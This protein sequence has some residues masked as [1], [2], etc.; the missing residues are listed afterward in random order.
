MLT[1]SAAVAAFSSRSVE[2]EGI[3]ASPIDLLICDGVNMQV[4]KSVPYNTG[5]DDDRR[6]ILLTSA[7][8]GAAFTFAAE[9]SG[10]FE[11]DFRVYSDVTPEV[12][13]LQ[14]Y[15]A[16]RFDLE[17]LTFTFTDVEN[18]NSFSV[19]VY[20]GYTAYNILPNAKVK[21][22]YSTI[23]YWY[24]K[25]AL[26]QT[27]L[28]NKNYAGY[29]TVFFGTSF[30]NTSY[31]AGGFVNGN[32]HSNHI[33]FDPASMEV[34]GYNYNENTGDKE[35]RV[36][37]DL[38]D[39]SVIGKYNCIEGFERYTVS[40][41]MSKITSG[42][43]GKV[44]LYALGG[45]SLSGRTFT[46]DA[47]PMFY[48][49]KDQTDGVVG[50]KIA[51]DIPAVCFDTICGETEF[52]G[53]IAV[54]TP[55]GELL[56]IQS[57]YFTPQEGGDYEVTY[58]AVDAN[59]VTGEIT[60][61]FY[62]YEKVPETEITYSFKAFNEDGEAFLPLNN[63]MVLPS[64]AIY[65]AMAREIYAVKPSVKDAEGEACSLDGDFFVPS[66][67]GVYTVLYEYT[68]PA[69]NTVADK[70]TVIAADV[71]GTELTFETEKI[72]ERDTLLMLPVCVSEN[73]ETGVAEVVYPSG[74]VSGGEM[75]YLDEVGGYVLK[76]SFAENENEY[77]ICRYF[78]V[79][80]TGAS[81]FKAVNNAEIVND[82]TAPEYFGYEYNG[83]G[84]NIKK[85]GATIMYDG[86]LDLSRSTKRDVLLD[87][88]VTPQTA[89][90]EEFKYFWITLTDIHD[91]D[92]YISICIR[93]DPWGS[94]QQ[95]RCSVKTSSMVDYWGQYTQGN[96]NPM[97]N[98]GT[99]VAT[100][101]FGKFSE[102]FMAHS[103]KL[104]Y[105]AEENAVYVS[106]TAHA[107]EL[108]D[109]RYLV[110]DLDDEDVLGSAYTF[111]GFTT[112]EV[113]LTIEAEGVSSANASYIIKTVA[114][115]DL[116]GAMLSGDSFPSMIVDIENTAP[117]GLTGSKYKI[118][119]ASAYD[120][121]DGT[122]EVSSE[123]Y[124]KEGGGLVR[125]YNPLNT[126]DY[127]VPDQAGIYYIVYQ[128]KNS[129]GRIITKE[130]GITVK[131]KLSDFSIDFGTPLPDEML[132]GEKLNIGDYSILG[133]SGKTECT[134]KIVYN[135]KEE[136]AG[137]IFQPTESGKYTLRFYLSDYVR[138]ETLEMDISVTDGGL[139]IF[140]E[141]SVPEYALAG[142][143]IVF[144]LPEAK[145]YEK[146]EIYDAAVK[147]TVTE[148]GKET[149]LAANAYDVTGTD[150]EI[151]NVKYE[152]SANGKIFE[153]VYTVNIVSPE[154]LKDYWIAENAEA[155]ELADSLLFRAT[156]EKTVLKF[157]NA[158]LYS[159]YSLS[160]Q[161][162]EGYNDF[163]AVG[164]VLSDSEKTAE[165]VEIEFRKG[166]NTSAV[167]VNGKYKGETAATFFGSIQNFYISLDA[168]Y[169]L[170]DFG[171][172]LICKL[173]SYINNT[174]FTG[175]SSGK[176][177][178]QIAFSGNKGTSGIR[179]FTLGN[180]TFYDSYYDEIKPV[181]TFDSEF[182]YVK[183]IGDEVVLSGAYA[184]D[185]LDPETELN[186]TVRLDGETV[187][188]GAY[189]D[190]LRFTIDKEGEYIITFTCADS[191]GNNAR[192]TRTFIAVAEGG[193]NINVN[194]SVPESGKTGKTIKLPSASVDS[195][196]DY[197]LFIFVID[198]LGRFMAAEKS[199]TPEINGV[200][201][202]RYAVQS[203]GGNIYFQ[204]YHITVK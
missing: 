159:N 158:T 20:G 185:V 19:V 190:D 15:N 83:V 27:K 90:V 142:K 127:F 169:N 96:F 134:V 74:K 131:D 192:T 147:I 113:Y 138:T 18:G 91:A 100:S 41:S 99:L 152:I 177:Y 77:E 13:S 129:A 135:G 29:N 67:V 22:K 80:N 202:V 38:N 12:T 59:G 117:D 200:Y 174:T 47:G 130:V 72:Y 30:C 23:G 150:G 126:E 53:S 21:L 39:A 40:C 81:V 68:G 52:N 197:E 136:T 71:P 160:F 184:Y 3:Y 194:G 28:Y 164:I 58:S 146:G 62:V 144:A 165:Q 157:I 115:Q 104:Y 98:N 35:K 7:E 94:L 178:T 151:L 65:D 36:I 82:A 116:G 42:R 124:K 181:I 97:V 198:P 79:V 161:I 102:T 123:I 95:S 189:R 155:E 133:G 112:G 24:N 132:T 122:L 107:Y 182:D 76:Y 75:V 170:Y 49:E 108:E 141:F 168:D 55:S 88:L 46:D 166:S 45:Q 172:K 2:A 69:G 199:F 93:D 70:F 110:L 176:I 64:A 63:A 50:G 16:S 8:T 85:D 43:E 154:K 57:G 120:V 180:Q 54:K 56:K 111:D 44:L 87:I 17:E 60:R 10:R 125:Y 145:V 204:D 48:F 33:C 128:A 179:L 171:G 14:A 109:D 105:D 26:S 143:R 148:N 162:N 9:M 203:S 89:G 140:D 92:R 84:V 201:I 73:G 139:P 167:Y 119:R 86:I 163:D 37:C 32:I 6:G 137:E 11:L 183:T 173:D 78:D 31:T 187:F 196:G 61:K 34:Y 191:S 186:V 121:I 1:A 156:A 101:F 153:K 114:G 51:L 66:E 106:K 188:D 175:F 103:L 4:D 149:V 25:G 5:I 193:V 195:A 118:F